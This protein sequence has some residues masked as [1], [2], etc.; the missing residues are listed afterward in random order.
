MNELDA[1]LRIVEEIREQS[2]LRFPPEAYLFIRK[3]LDFTVDRITRKYGLAGS[4][5]IT[6]KEFLDGFRDFA[7]DQFG[8]MTHTVLNS[9]NFHTCGDVGDIVFQ[10]VEFG[11][12]GRS[13]HDSFADFD[14]GYDFLE[15]FETPWKT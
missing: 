5:H 8:P 13:D 6:G 15:T 12:M 10:M 1:F 14:D 2:E 3:T 9:W 4:F 11:L 7:L